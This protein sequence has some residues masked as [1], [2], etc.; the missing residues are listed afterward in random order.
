M[1]LLIALRAIRSGNELLKAGDKFLIEDGQ[2]LVDRGYARRLTR[3]ETRA[4]LESYV[5]EA[6]KMFSEIPEK[7]TIPEKRSAIVQERLFDI[8]ELRPTES[9]KST[10]RRDEPYACKI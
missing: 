8:Q 9:Y 6:E 5:R 3:N 7:K 4:I 1:E 10:L 2:G